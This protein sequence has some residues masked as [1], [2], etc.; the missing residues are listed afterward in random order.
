MS[1]DT[2]PNPQTL[3]SPYRTAFLTRDQ[4]VYIRVCLE[5][6][7]IL[8]RDVIPQVEKGVLGPLIRAPV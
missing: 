1:S 2:Y 3:N 8:E 4:G 5:Y 6:L 7:D